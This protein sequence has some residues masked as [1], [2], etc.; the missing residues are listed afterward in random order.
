M[1]DFKPLLAA[2]VFL[3]F[4]LIIT[5]AQVALYTFLGRVWP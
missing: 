3:V 1:R 5:G 4:F 2:S